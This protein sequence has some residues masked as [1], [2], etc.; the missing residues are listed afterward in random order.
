VFGAGASI[1]EGA[2]LQSDILKQVFESNDKQLSSSDVANQVRLFIKD[3]FDISD[4]KY[5]TLESIFGYMEY[6][7]YKREGLGKEYTTQKI[8][9]IKEALIR[10]VH[11]V[12]SQPK[13]NRHGTYRQFWDVISKTNRNVSVVTM[14]YD[15]LLD[16][17]FDS[18]YPDRAYIDYCI[19]LMNYHYYDDLSAFDWWINPREPIEVWEG[20]SPKPIKLI[21]V[22]GSL[23]WK[24]C[25][26]CNQVLLTVW[27]NNID[28]GS[29]GFK[30]YGYSGG[31]NPKEVEFDLSCPLDGTKFDT[32]I[33]PP[34]HIKDL[35][36]PAINKLLDETAI[37][38]RKAKKIVFVGY[39]FPEADVHIKALFKK[40]LRTDTEIHV[41]DPFLNSTIRS[42]YKSLSAA[43]VFYEQTFEQFVINDLASVIKSPDKKMQ[44]TTKA[45]S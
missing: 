30:G 29:M 15:T 32:C 16:E 3:N 26:C 2:P 31:V 28:L 8:T 11:Y 44:S 18:L 38:I 35:S 39:S 43:P 36:H 45:M 9:E 13:G 4:G 14:N 20:T 17:A 27:D 42:N 22:H 6:F 34:S 37:E 40:N 23:N 25:N 7:I 19:E 21:K 1:A 24:Y 10:L 33:V 12:I 5:P 41:V